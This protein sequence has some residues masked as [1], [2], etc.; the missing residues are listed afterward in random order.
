[1][2]IMEYIPAI[3]QIFATY[4][5]PYGHR[6][7]LTIAQNATT[8]VQ[9]CHL[10]RDKTQIAQPFIIDRADNRSTRAYNVP[11]GSL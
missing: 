1:M 4:Q 3:V 10:Q 8:G 7:A 6:M 5:R 11:P 9:H 2:Q